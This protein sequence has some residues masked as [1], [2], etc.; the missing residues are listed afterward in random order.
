MTLSL[1]LTAAKPIE[2]GLK[3]NSAAKAMNIVEQAN[4]EHLCQRM[5]E[6]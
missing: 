1:V 3:T 6:S 4:E 5:D 2:S